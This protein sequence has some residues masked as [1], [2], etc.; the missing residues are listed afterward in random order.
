MVATYAAKGDSFSADKSRE[1]SDRQILEITSL[2]W[3]FYVAPD[4]K[5]AVVWTRP[6]TGGQKGAVHVM[7]LEN[8]FDERR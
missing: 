4:G 2:A 7:V 3:N 8:F 6:E 1:W 5:R